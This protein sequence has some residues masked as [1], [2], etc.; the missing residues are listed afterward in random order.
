MAGFIEADYENSLIE[1]FRNMGYQYVYGPDVERDYKDPLYEEVLQDSIYR[2]NPALPEPAIQDALYKLK[3]FEN[4]TLVQK[5]AVFMNYLQNGIEV[6]YHDHGE[7]KSD[8][9]Y[10]VDYQH[11]DNNSF[12]VTNQWTYIENSKKRPDMLLF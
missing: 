3:H 2:L 1:L 9:V 10:I 12:I 6:S 5:N 4:G 8:I 7:V 11:P